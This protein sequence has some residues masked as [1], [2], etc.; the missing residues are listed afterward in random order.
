MGILLINNW[1][2]RA[3]TKWAVP[4]LG[5][6]S[7]VE[8]ESRLS[9]PRG[10]SQEAVFLHGLSRFLTW[11][12]AASLSWETSTVSRNKPLSPQVA[13]AVV[14]CHSNRK[15]IRTK[16]RGFKKCLRF[17]IIFNVCVCVVCYSWAVLT[18]ARRG[19]WI[20]W[21]QS[22]RYLSVSYLTLVLGNDLWSSG[23][24]RT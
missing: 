21:R 15:L 4:P 22:Y 5:R 23:K 24:N 6:C 16:G 14:L 2:G 18:E 19:H 10:A 7:W 13:F 20:P 9:K 17:I 12:P 11:V 8:W 1:C 3:Q